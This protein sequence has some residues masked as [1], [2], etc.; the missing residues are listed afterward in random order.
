MKKRHIA[1]PE[2]DL[3]LSIPALKHKQQALCPRCGGVLTRY[4]RHSQHKLLAFAL[5]SAIF[6]L[7]SLKFPFLVFSSH[8]HTKELT[9]LQSMQAFGAA[10]YYLVSGV[11]F[12]SA[13][14][15]PALFISG[16]TY[17]LWS[18]DRKKLLPFTASVLRLTL[19]LLPWNMAEIFLVGVFVSLI[20]VMTLAQVSLEM[21]FYSYV[22]F[23]LNLAA[24]LLYL[25]KYQLW[26]L[27]QI[28]LKH[29]NV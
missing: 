19:L 23:I 8:G 4:Y 26:C 24:T 11:L 1:C 27:Y 17:V 25:D 22:L 2:C 13:I 10:Q 28:R 9:L 20:K 12:F 16:I 3:L 5:T 7:L 15:I 18:F 6:L 29:Q 21:S 14:I